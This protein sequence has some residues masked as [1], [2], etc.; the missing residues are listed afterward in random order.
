M[1]S[2]D[3]GAADFFDFLRRVGDDPVTTDK[4]RRRVAYVADCDGVDEKVIA[5]LGLRAIGRVARLDLHANAVRRRV[6]HRD[7]GKTRRAADT[8]DFALSGDLLAR[9]LC[10]FVL[11][12]AACVTFSMRTLAVL[13]VLDQI[14]FPVGIAVEF[15]AHKHAGF[16]MAFLIGDAVF[17]VIKLL[18]ELA[19]NLSR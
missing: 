9:G 3:T 11:A 7:L 16:V 1:I 5:R 4:L 6:G 17:V 12:G 13:K 18:A 19:I 8:S 15:I 2:D 10:G 14:D